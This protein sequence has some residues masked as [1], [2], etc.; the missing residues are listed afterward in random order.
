MHVALWVINIILAII[1]LF[2]G[3]MKMGRSKA[4][5]LK[6]GM[7]WVNDVSAPN[8]KLLGIAEVAGAL[9]LI[10]P[11]AVDIVPILTP[12]ASVCLAVVMFG[13]VILHIRNKEEWLMPLI[14]FLGTVASAI[15]G[16]MVI[17]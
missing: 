4:S 9:G 15:I 8:I 16:F 3:G 6:A 10:L 11:Y 13:A 14:I 12:I 7:T 2:A 5:M 1:F 17:A